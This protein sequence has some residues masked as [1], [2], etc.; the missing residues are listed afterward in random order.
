MSKIV[1]NTNLSVAAALALGETEHGWLLV[2][3][4]REQLA[5]LSTSEREAL[6]PFVGDGEKP[7]YSGSSLTVSL[8]GWLGVVEALRAQISEVAAEKAA[9]EAKIRAEIEC[10]TEILAAPRQYEPGLPLRPAHSVRAPNYSRYDAKAKELWAEIERRCEIERRA[11]V[12]DA[13]LALV[14]ELAEVDGRYVE[15]D[16]VKAVIAA[17]RGFKDGRFQ[18]VIEIPNARRLEAEAK[19]LNDEADENRKRILRDAARAYVQGI[20]GYAR[21]CEDPKA[22]LT[23]VAR[24]N[25]LV[26]VKAV[27]DVEWVDGD[28]RPC[29][30]PTDAAYS[31][32]DTVR[33]ELSA[34]V[35]SA[36]A[37][38][39][40]VR[41]EIVRLDTCPARGCN[42]GWR[43]C[44]VATVCV[45]GDE[46]VVACV[47]DADGPHEHESDDE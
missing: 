39:K 4:N 26:K 28:E 23:A 35:R 20:E 36:P 5:D 16:Q 32:L 3:P 40:I 41:C 6:K 9:K 8:P 25:L 15:S 47:A 12:Q 7:K 27:G 10:Y 33:D 29:D 22:D 17:A 18:D 38:V 21:A 44:V 45:A 37:L 31:A 19:R 1:I 30:A 43:V 13:D 11:I 14:D 42:Q 24:R 34:L 46:V 2:T